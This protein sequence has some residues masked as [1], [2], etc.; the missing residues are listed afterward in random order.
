MG[1]GNAGQGIILHRFFWYKNIREIFFRLV[2]ANKRSKKPLPV[3]VE[4]PPDNFQTPLIRVIR[5]S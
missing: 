4:F 3:P 1:A 2:Y 5:G